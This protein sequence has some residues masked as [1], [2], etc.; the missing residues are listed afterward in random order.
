[1]KENTQNDS[2]DLVRSTMMLRLF[3]SKEPTKFVV[4]NV[5]SDQIMKSYTRVPLLPISANDKSYD[6]F[7][8]L[9]P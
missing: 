4:R 9:T 5:T 3:N 8:D 7:M 1:M 6:I 2:I